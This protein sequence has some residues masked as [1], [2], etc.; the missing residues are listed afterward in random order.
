MYTRESGLSHETNNITKQIHVATASR[1]VSWQKDSM[2]VVN[3]QSY[4][5]YNIYD[6]VHSSLSISLEDKQI[7]LRPAHICT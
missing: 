4:F 1:T 6:S 5:A 2:W 3:V 7:Y